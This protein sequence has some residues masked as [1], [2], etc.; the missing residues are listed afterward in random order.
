MVLDVKCVLCGD[1][2]CR[3]NTIGVS[4]EDRLTDDIMPYGLTQHVNSPTHKDGNMLDLILTLNADANYISSQS[5]R[6]ICFSDHHLLCCELGI[7]TPPP[8]TIKYSFRRINTMNIDA[9]HSSML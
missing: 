5:V 1:F 2:N 3:S 6:S 8:T 4:L 9:F 7:N